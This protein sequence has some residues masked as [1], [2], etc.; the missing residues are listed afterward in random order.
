MSGLRVE[1]STDAG[2]TIPDSLDALAA[3]AQNPTVSAEACAV[4]LQGEV[5]RIFSDAANPDGQWESLSK[6]T[7]FL[8]RHRASAP[9]SSDTPGSDTGRL[10]GSF[11][12]EWESDG[13]M[14]GAGTNV[15]YAERFDMGGD[16][17]PNDVAIRGFR[18]KNMKRRTVD[19]VMHMAGGNQVPARR[20]FPEGMDGLESWGWLDK[21]REIFAQG[22]K[23]LLGSTA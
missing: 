13:T 7:M 16:S 11:R 4:W 21:I 18:R 19:F 20:F 8:R 12:P 15:E 9:R 10:K 1:V 5:T 22:F 2:A 6:V 3:A 17:E 23:P 14:F